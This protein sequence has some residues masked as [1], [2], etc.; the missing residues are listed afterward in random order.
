MDNN[1]VLLWDQYGDR[2]NTPAMNHDDAVT[3]VSFHPSENQLASG[4]YDQ[5]VKIWTLA[6]EPV[7]ILKG[8]S[9]IVLDVEYHPQGEVLAS[10]SADGTVKLWRTNGTLIRTLKVSDWCFDTRL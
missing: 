1:K 4:S 2:L 7:K 10:A 8:H 3:S 6:G 9:D 5:T